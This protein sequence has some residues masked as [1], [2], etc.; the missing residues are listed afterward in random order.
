M[1]HKDKGMVQVFKD[2]DYLLPVKFSA[3]KSWYLYGNEYFYTK[4]FTFI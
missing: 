2:K 3:R 1:T 4:F